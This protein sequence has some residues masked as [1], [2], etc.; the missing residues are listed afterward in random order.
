MSEA[1][2]DAWAVELR[3]RRDDAHERL[4]AK[5]AAMGDDYERLPADLSWE[6]YCD[7]VESSHHS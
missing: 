7:L 6:E 4:D 3:R 2:R 5:V 1:E